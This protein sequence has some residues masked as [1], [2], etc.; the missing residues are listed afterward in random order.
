M[1]DKCTSNRYKCP[2][3]QL[4]LAVLGFMIFAFYGLIKDIS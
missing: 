4:I 3:P 2:G 1:R